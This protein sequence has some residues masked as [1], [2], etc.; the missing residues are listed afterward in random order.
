MA[1]KTKPQTKQE[2]AE[3]LAEDVLNYIWYPAIQ[4]NSNWT[5][6]YWEGPVDKATIWLETGRELE[7]FIYSPDGFFAVW[8]KLEERLMGTNLTFNHIPEN[9]NVYCTIIKQYPHAEWSSKTKDRYESFYNAVY[10]IW[11]DN[12]TLKENKMDFGL[13]IKSMK[14]GEK[15]YRAGW[16][17]KGIFIELQVPD[18]NSKMTSPYIYMN[19]T[20]LQTDN[21]KAPKSLV[22]WLASQTDM[23]ADD[24]YIVLGK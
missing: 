11:K 7:E 18:A 19:T 14:N 16:N 8:D 4:V 23:L 21:E 5:Q 24:W 12:L 22:P 17:G 13:A 2:M 20:G 15:V 6:P 1:T 3:W 10:E 9:G